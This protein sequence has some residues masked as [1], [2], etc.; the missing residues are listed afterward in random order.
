[1]KIPIV[2]SFDKNFILPAQIAIYSL[3]TNA[4]KDT[5][6]TIYAI[7]SDKDVASLFDI[8]SLKKQF[9][10][11]NMRFLYVDNA[12]KDSYE[13]R[14]ITVA[15]YYRLLI[16]NLLSDLE[17]VIYMDV[18]VIIQLDFAKIFQIDLGDNY[19]GGFLD[20]GMSLT[21][22]GR[23]YLEEELKIETDKYIQSGFL[24]MNLKKMR[25]DRLVQ[26]MQK[27]STRKFPYQDQDILNIACVGRTE[28]LPVHFNVVLQFY[29]MMKDHEEDFKN[30]DITSI[31]RTAI[32]HYNGDKPWNKS[33]MND[34]I[35]WEYYRKSPYFNADFYKNAQLKP[36]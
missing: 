3:L 33:V 14:G 11:F 24:L 35:W 16:P 2:V 17:K 34:D 30:Y 12:F 15:A 4:N 8:A 10:H 13:V 6:Y 9:P 32:I 26:K 31:L 25:D 5:Q 28:I 7:T 20:Y 21:E 18:D 1:M 19:V 29:G 23:K 27:L 36:S 22:S